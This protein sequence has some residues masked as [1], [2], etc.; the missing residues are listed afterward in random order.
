MGRTLSN[1]FAEIFIPFTC[2]VC[3]LIIVETD[4]LLQLRAAMENLKLLLVSLQLA[5]AL[6]STRVIRCFDWGQNLD[7]LANSSTF[8][9]PWILK[10][11]G[12]YYNLQDFPAAAILLMD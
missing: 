7:F 10:W 6:V 2:F 4:V 8:T 11:K 1:I 9:L 12:I 5:T 3:S